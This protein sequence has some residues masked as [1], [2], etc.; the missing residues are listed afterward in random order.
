MSLLV[1]FVLVILGEFG[2]CGM[3]AWWNDILSSRYGSI[4]QRLPHW[5]EKQRSPIGRE[6]DTACCSRVLIPQ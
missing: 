2:F 1:L 3:V 6:F 4:A 5:T